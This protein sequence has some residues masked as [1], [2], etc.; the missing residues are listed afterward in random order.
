MTSPT[1]T[2]PPP[3]MDPIQRKVWHRVKAGAVLL[4]IAFALQLIH[5]LVLHLAGH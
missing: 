1:L 4:A 2:A 3:P 5:S